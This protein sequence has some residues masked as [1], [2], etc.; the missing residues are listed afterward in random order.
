M[1]PAYS[2]KVSRVS[3]YSGSCHVILGFMYGAFTLSGRLSQNRSITLD[4]SF[5]QS[6]PSMHARWFG[7]FPVRSPLL[8]KSSFSFFSSGYLDVSVHR[9]PSIRYGLAYG[10]M[11]S[12]H[13]GFPI[14][15][16]PDHRI[17]APPRSLSQLITSF[18]G[19][20]CQGIRPALFLLGLSD[21]I[22][23]ISDGL[24][25]C[26]FSTSLLLQRLVSSLSLRLTYF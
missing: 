23:L 12:S 11:R 7:L 17:F 21:I 1:V 16:S 24:L 13:V 5:L 4:E 25:V 26:C 19:S 3:W 20:Q 6:N 18:I 14:Q 9:V 2:H 10:Y 8:R 15:K 22:A